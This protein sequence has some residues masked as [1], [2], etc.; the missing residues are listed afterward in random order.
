MILLKLKDREES[1]VCAAFTPDTD[2]PSAEKRCKENRK[3]IKMIE[4]DLES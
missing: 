2:S 1:F 4:D 3:E